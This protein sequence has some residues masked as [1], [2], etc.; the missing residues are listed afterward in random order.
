MSGTVKDIID[1][2]A[3]V[4]A[5]GVKEGVDR[6]MLRRYT[7]HSHTQY[8]DGRAHMEAFAAK[9][10]EDGFSVYGFTPHS[11]VPI[12]SS[13]NMHRDNVDVYIKEAQR[14]ARMYDGRMGILTG[15][16]V[17]WLGSQWNA[18]IDY[19]QSMKLD[20]TISS[21]HFLQSRR[22]EW[23]DIDGRFEGFRQK[24]GRYFDDD[25]RYVVEKY[26][27][28]SIRMVERGGFD[29][30][31]HF[32][33]IGHNAAHFCEGIE[34]ERWYESLVEDLMEAIV[35]SGKVVEINTKAF[36]EHGRFFPSSCRWKR[37]VDSGVKLVVNSDAHVPALINAGRDEAFA[38]LDNLTLEKR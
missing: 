31:G 17:D 34:S 5:G 32:D 6:Q 9:A 29:I 38:I 20:Y 27:E 3:G 24:M 10:C 37:L 21:V 1:G 28:E 16:E 23:V 26:Y 4:T 18:S 30:V 22:G 14:L 35:K 7:L 2:L 19:F 11:P 8:C 13:C 12:V 25:I 36:R 15:M 33:K